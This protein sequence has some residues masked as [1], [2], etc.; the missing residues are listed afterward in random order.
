MKHSV[1]SRAV[2]IVAAAMVAACGGGG[3]PDEQQ[4]SLDSA[5][6]IS[7]ENEPTM[8]VVQ[9]F[10]VHQEAAKRAVGVE[11]V[12]GTPRV[13]RGDDPAPVEDA[14]SVALT[15]R[16]KVT[17]DRATDSFL[18]N[19]VVEDKLA[20]EEVRFA[21][22]DGRLYVLRDIYLDPG[23]APAM[24]GR[25]LPAALDA[26]DARQRAA[27]LSLS[28]SSPAISSLAGISSSA[29][30]ISN[31]VISV[32]C[33]SYN[34]ARVA[35]DAMGTA[36]WTIAGTGFG[37]SIGRASLNGS[38]VKITSWSSTKVVVDPSLP[39]SASVLNNSILQLTTADGKIAKWLVTVAPAI[40]LRVY[41]QCTYG[42]AKKRYQLG[43]Q[44]SPTAYG[45][46][47]AFGA[48]YVPK[49]GD[50]LQWSGKHVAIISRVYS[51]VSGSNGLLT[52]PI[53]MFEQNFNCLSSTTTTSTS[54]AVRGTTVVARPISRAYANEQAS[55]WYR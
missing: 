43:L 14:G 5:P 45:G 25:G 51:P 3:A 21:K 19:G 11:V 22:A 55:A 16:H 26:P 17:H 52:W 49:V 1:F 41:G 2:A 10:D 28:S 24:A 40:K 7:A 44:P 20:L 37:S 31:G 4:D 48:A 50:Q 6:V 18:I 29:S 39:W 34:G 23:S 35:N 36:P 54:F 30:G 47:S 38:T 32:T 42:V 12:L 9:H 15:A 13:F 46:Y 8:S 33:G 27:A 53:E